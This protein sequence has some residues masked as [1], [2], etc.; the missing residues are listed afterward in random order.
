MQARSLQWLCTQSIRGRADS[1]PGAR[2]CS[3]Q[4]GVLNNLVELWRYPS[5]Q[6]SLRFQTYHLEALNPLLCD[7]DHNS[8]MALASASD[9]ATA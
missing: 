3:L 9:S 2:V 1:R 5:A 8:P 7:F 6:A 4:V